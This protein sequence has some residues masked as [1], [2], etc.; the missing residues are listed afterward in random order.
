MTEVIVLGAGVIGLTSALVLSE[1]GYKVTVIASN[2][3][4]DELT[5]KYTSPWAGA[6]Y[7]PFPSLTEKDF[8]D[9]QL[10]RVTY[11][12]F[13]YLA[14]QEPESSIKFIEGID[15]VENKGVYGIK[16]KGYFEEIEE[17]RELEDLPD[18][19]SFGASYKT[20]VLNS[21]LYLQYLYR[22][23]IFKF[24]VHFIRTEIIS[25]KQIFQN[26]PKLTVVNASGLGLQ[27][28]GGYDS[29][30]SPIRGQT[31]LVRV[32]P[33]C[34]YLEKTVTHQSKDGLW[35]FVIPRP[36]GGVI[37]GGTKQLNDLQSTE[38][39]ADTKQLIARGQLLFPELFVDGK[40]DIRNVNVG[41]R[42]AR[43]NGV[44]VE[45]ERLKEGAIIHAYGAG[46]MGY[47]LS[48]GVALKV[49]DIIEGN[50]I[51]SKL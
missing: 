24:G 18:G 40:L 6:H 39:E 42:P 23:L 38:R 12:Y 25:L 15:Y 37:L 17:M 49:L 7:R 21:P 45:L 2:F 33:G 13:K 41:F 47:E 46:G 3:P 16:S 5:P 35:T 27:Y 4:T 44:R 22:K 51:A 30:S 50:S 10:T 8:Q 9:S 48:Y 31:L 29:E 1:K 14:L 34:P 11:K 36:F 20:W 19:V 26:F 28:D 43:K 32:P